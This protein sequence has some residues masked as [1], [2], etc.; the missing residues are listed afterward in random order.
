MH[1]RPKTVL[2]KGYQPPAPG[3]NQ[4][5]GFQF[6]PFVEL[7]IATLSSTNTH[8]DRTWRSR[9]NEWRYGLTPLPRCLSFCRIQ[10]RISFSTASLL[11]NTARKL[12]LKSCVNLFSNTSSSLENSDVGSSWEER[13][14]LNAELGVDW[15]VT[16][17]VKAGGFWGEVF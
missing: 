13:V 9:Q 14:E 12:F 7:G 1:V 15:N 11:V 8:P 17:P 3:M 4:L 10:L 5:K 2:T 6:G 16:R